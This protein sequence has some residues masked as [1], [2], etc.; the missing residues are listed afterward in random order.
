MKYTY[1]LTLIA[2]LVQCKSPK[3]DNSIDSENQKRLDEWYAKQS[4][5]KKERKLEYDKQ[6]S[7]IDSV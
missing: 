2:F 6:I 3:N 7:K 1:F 4:K 5:E